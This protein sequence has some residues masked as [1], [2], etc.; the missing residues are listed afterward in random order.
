MLAVC[1]GACGLALAHWLLR[2][3]LSVAPADIPRLQEVRLD[4]A[5][6]LFSLAV[7]LLAAVV[8]RPG[9]RLDRGP[10]RPQRGLGDGGSRLSGDGRGKRLR[11]ALI[12]AEVAI[13]VVLLLGAALVV[14][15]FVR[16]QQ[17]DLGFEPRNVLTMQLQPRGAAYATPEAR[18]A[19]FRQLTARLEGQPG[20]VAASAVLIRP[21]EGTVGWE[22]SYASDAPVS[23]RRAPERDRELRGRLAPLLPHPRDRA[24]GREGVRSRGRSRTSGGW[25]S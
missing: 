19:F 15:S 16:L 12:V 7:T 25:S 5:G 3:L 23:G 9:S 8:L 13:S 11:G 17:V 21:L 24:R 14:Q 4:G 2:L 22:A 10:G 6:L 18:R 1:G 20:V